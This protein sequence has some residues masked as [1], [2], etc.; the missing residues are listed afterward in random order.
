[1]IGDYDQTSSGCTIAAHLRSMVG[2][3][4]VYY[5]AGR[6]AWYIDYRD[7]RGKRRHMRG[8]DTQAQAEIMLAGMVGDTALVRAGLTTARQLDFKRWHNT[9]IDDLITEYVKHLRGRRLS[10]AH[11]ATTEAMIKAW[12]A[13]TSVK[14]LGDADA[15]RT[16]AWLAD[17]LDAGWSYRTRNGY[18]KAAKALLRWCEK[19]GRIEA[20]PLRAI[21]VLNE[22]E[23]RK[24]IS[25]AL[26]PA[27]L[28]TLLEACR[29]DTRRVYYML[30]ARMGL[31]WREIARLKWSQF[32]LAEGW[33]TLTSA[34]TKA[35]RADVLPIPGD[36]LPALVKLKA[37]KIGDGPLFDAMPDRRTWARDLKRAKI[38]YTTP[39]GNADRKCL[40]KTFCT[41]L[42]LG[43]A[44]IRDAQMLMRHRDINLTA[45]VYTDPRLQDLRAAAERAAGLGAFGVHRAIQSG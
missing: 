35:K 9:P 34:G 43:G 11:V 19:R 42:Y 26:A 44:D 23:D 30:A 3:A 45:R 2:M 32:D 8:G 10:P 14:S 41:H 37:N 1:M 12:V 7:A 21:D 24:R 29:C 20:S 13:G 39:A 31:R 18:L 25:R 17:Q 16:E 38:V 28:A 5:R 4:R 33:L 22:D 6:A 15:A 27:E 36:V 40:R